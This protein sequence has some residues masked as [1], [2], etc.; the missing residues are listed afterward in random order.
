MKPY[1]HKIEINNVFE[2]NISKNVSI[3]HPLRSYKLGESRA[4]SV[5]N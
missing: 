1:T 4:E 2:A 3:R 5:E